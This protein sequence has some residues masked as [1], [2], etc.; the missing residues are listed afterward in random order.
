VL[1]DISLHVAAGECVAILGATGGVA[2]LSRYV[3]SQ[4]LE[5]IGQDYVRT[6]QAKGLPSE[7]VYYK[8]ALRN[9]LLPFVT[10]FGLILPG[11]I[12]GSV[13]IESIFS[14]PGMGRMAYEAILGR[15]YPV[16]LTINFITAVL[17]LVGTLISD[18]LYMVVDPRIKL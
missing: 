18:L 6:A 4:M 5:I 2:V 16:I 17:V 3:R 1:K 14:W 9:A 10:M 11:L 13:I 7:T 15:D 8:H 12:G